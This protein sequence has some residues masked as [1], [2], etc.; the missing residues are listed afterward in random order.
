MANLKGKIQQA[1]SLLNSSLVKGFFITIKRKSGFN[2]KRLYVWQETMGNIQ[3]ISGIETS[4]FLLPL[5]EKWVSIL[6]KYY[7]SIISALGVLYKFVKRAS[8]F[9]II[10]T[11][12]TQLSGQGY[13]CNRVNFP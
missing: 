10:D 12:S 11:V 5:P 4:Q 1:K 9:P 3:D 8:I 2:I 7:Q 6:S 13:A